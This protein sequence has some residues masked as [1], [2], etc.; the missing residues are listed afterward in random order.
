MPQE[1]YCPKIRGKGAVLNFSPSWRSPLLISQGPIQIMAACFV[2]NALLMSVMTGG[3]PLWPW[4]RTGRNVE[5]RPPLGVIEGC[6]LQVG[7]DHAPA[8]LL[9]EGHPVA[10]RPRR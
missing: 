4:G 1:A 7:R 8:L 2:R 6:L 9:E 10:D 5:P 3:A